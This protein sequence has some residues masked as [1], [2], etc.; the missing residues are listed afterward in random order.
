VLAVGEQSPGFPAVEG[1]VGRQLSQRYYFLA[2]L[3]FYLCQNTSTDDAGMVRVTNS[4]PREWRQPSAGGMAP[5]A[6]IDRSR[7]GPYNS[8]Y[9][10]R[11]ESHVTAGMVRVT[12]RTPGVLAAAAPPDGDGAQRAVAAEVGQAELA[13]RA[14]QV[15]RQRQHLDDRQKHALGTLRIEARM[16]GW[17]GGLVVV[18]VLGGGQAKDDCAFLCAGVIIPLAFTVNFHF[19]FFGGRSRRSLCGARQS[20]GVASR[21]WRGDAP[22]CLCF[23]LRS[24]GSTLRVEERGRCCGERWTFDLIFFQKPTLLEFAIKRHPRVTFD[25]FFGRTLQS[26]A[27]RISPHTHQRPTLQNR[28]LVEEHPLT[29]SAVFLCSP[30]CSCV[31]G[32]VGRT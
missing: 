3:L 22:C 12:N 8:R 32:E 24:G 20:E 26:L 27:T 2:I 6:P 23:T 28:P 25:F 10:P 30:L 4:H 19:S 1:Y 9:G 16:V 13:A 15:D 14:A 7:Y 21:G 17:W 11:N 29:R 31:A 18:V 5:T